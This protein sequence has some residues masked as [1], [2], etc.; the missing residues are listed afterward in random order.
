MVHIFVPSFEQSYELHINIFFVFNILFILIFIT[1]ILNFIIVLNLQKIGH[2]Y[3]VPYISC[4]P[5]HQHSFP[6]CY[7]PLLLLT[8]V[9]SIYYK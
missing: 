9:W 5:P 3:R 8:L 7:I 2:W 1:N 4:L 6:Y